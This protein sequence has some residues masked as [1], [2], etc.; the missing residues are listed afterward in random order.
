MTTL[1]RAFALLCLFSFFTF[2]QSLPQENVHQLAVN[3]TAEMRV[4]ADR[5]FFSFSVSGY[6]SNLRDAVAK[7]SSKVGE[8]SK[9]LFNLGLRRGDL[10]TSNFYSGENP[11]GKPFLSSSKDFKAFINV[12]VTLDSL[13][14]LNDLVFALSESEVENISNIRF[15]VNKASEINIEARNKAIENAKLKAKQMSDQAGVILKKVIYLSEEPSY[16]YGAEMAN[17]VNYFKAQ[18]PG[19]QGAFYANTITVTSQVR[20]IFEIE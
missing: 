6:G 12:D 4:P 1:F 3:G 7:A 14:L 18:T 9:K 20:M 16:Y 8:V 5:A 10:F 11:E 19:G 2:G 15:V 17:S 13:S